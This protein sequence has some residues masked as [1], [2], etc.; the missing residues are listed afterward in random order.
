MLGL[1]GV[2]FATQLPQRG[3][4]FH[5]DTDGL[6]EKRIQTIQPKHL[7]LKYQS[8]IARD[9]MCNFLQQELLT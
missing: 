5:G 3:R 1:K 7:A 2:F 4:S 9:G 6:S 8:E